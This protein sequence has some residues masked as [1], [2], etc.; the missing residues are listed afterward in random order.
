MLRSVIFGLDRTLLDR[1]VSILAFSAS[2]FER[3][4]NRLKG[5]DRDLY[6]N[7]FVRLD[8][9]GS[10]WKDEVYQ[11]LISELKI[12]SVTWEELYSDLDT[13]VARLSSF[14]KAKG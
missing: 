3:F 4:Q 8:A 5:V 14:P 13:Q 9:R 6:L 10:A 11:R 1:D 2:Q 7:T 12:E